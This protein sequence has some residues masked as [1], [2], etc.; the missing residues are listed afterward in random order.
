MAKL[1][2]KYHVENNQSL[3]GSATF[4]LNPG[5]HIHVGY[6]RLDIGSTPMITY[7]DNLELTDVAI[8][9]DRIETLT[10][11]LT[12]NISTANVYMETQSFPLMKNGSARYETMI[13]IVLFTYTRT[14]GSH[15]SKE[16]KT[17][18]L[19]TPAQ[20]VKFMKQYDTWNNR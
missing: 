3:T 15:S 10:S 6:N 2:V 4:D 19:F 7:A 9:G 18:A 11:Q 1:N 12:D 13:L 8:V 5:E 20:L 17:S 16:T 14:D